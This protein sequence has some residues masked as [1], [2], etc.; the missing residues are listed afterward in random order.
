LIER[1]IKLDLILAH[2]M[3]DV[4]KLSLNSNLANMQAKRK[5]ERINF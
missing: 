2:A 3:L 4:K 1:E 5:K